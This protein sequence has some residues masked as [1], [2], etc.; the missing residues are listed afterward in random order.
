MKILCEKSEQQNKAHLLGLYCT[1]TVRVLEGYLVLK[2]TWTCYRT[3]LRGTEE[4]NT[5]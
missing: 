3:E 2:I 5:R 4:K 1:L